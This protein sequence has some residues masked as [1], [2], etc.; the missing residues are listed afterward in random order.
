MGGLNCPGDCDAKVSKE[1]ILESDEL[2]SDPA[3][4]SMGPVTWRRSLSLSE[5]L[6][7]V[8]VLQCDCG[9]SRRCS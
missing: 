4:T 3:S 7:L 1:A 8:C 5:P 2:D 9:D 6:S